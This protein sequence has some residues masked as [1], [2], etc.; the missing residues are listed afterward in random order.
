MAVDIVF[1]THSTSEDNERGIATGWLPGALSATGR[2][3]AGELGARRRATGVRVVFSSDLRRA[4]ATAQL[5][6]EGSGIPLRTDWRLRECN[7][8]A[9]NGMP[10][11]QL[12]A[13]RRHR[14][15]EPFPDGESYRQVVERVRAFLADLARDWEGQQVLL[16][17]H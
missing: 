11:A 15:D 3:Q 4:V 8:G 9:L 16:V 17:G 5:A 7:Y 6:F 13:E 10:V 1:E 12:E 2:E 14:I